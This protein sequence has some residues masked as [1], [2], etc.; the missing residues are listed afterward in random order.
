MYWL[1]GK[2]FA[3]SAGIFEARERS[4]RPTNDSAKTIVQVSAGAI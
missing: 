1:T 4:T 3:G 2:M